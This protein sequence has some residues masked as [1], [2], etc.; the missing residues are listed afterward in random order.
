MMDNFFA[1]NYPGPAFQLFGA[2]HIFALIAIVLLNLFIIF[3]FKKANEKTKHNI[4]WALAIILWTNEIGWHLWHI[5]TGTWTIQTM[6][7]LHLCSVLVWTGALMLVTKN[8]SIYEFCYFLGIGG[9]FQAVLTPDLGIYG[10]PHYRFFQTFISHGLIITAA[11]YM[12]V[13]ENFRPTWKSMLR[14]SIWMNIYMVIVYFINSAIGSDYLMIN[15]KPATASILDLLPPW[16]VYIIYMEILGV[17]TFL[18]LYLPFIIKDWRTKY[19]TARDSAIRLD[20][21]AK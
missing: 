4:R 10:F 20:K 19:V 8:Y 13:I 18:I 2:S 1:V 12:T 11:I 5:F 3:R 15:A 21:H 17:V 14:V 9:A 7:P 6:L 16:P